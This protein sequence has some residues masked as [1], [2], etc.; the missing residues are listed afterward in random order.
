MTRSVPAALCAPL[1]L[2]CSRAAQAR[3]QPDQASA[4]WLGAWLRVFTSGAPFRGGSVARGTSRQH[5]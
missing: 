3:Y 5:R 4:N 2:C 1:P